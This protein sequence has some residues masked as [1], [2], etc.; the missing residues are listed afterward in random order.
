MPLEKLDAMTIQAEL[1]K[2]AEVK[3]LTVKVKN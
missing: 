2:L 1:K 3:W